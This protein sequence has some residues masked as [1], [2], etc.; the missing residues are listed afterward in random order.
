MED[1]R[2]VNQAGW[3]ERAP[4]HAASP[5]YDVERFAEDPAFLSKVVRFD[6]PLLGDVTGLRGVHL[7]CH[8]GTDTISL[9]RLGASMTGLDY[10]A[11]ALALARQL[12]ERTGDDATFVQADVYDAAS[13]LGGGRFDLVFTGI[14]ALCWLPSIRRWAEVVAALLRPGGRLFIRE[15]HPMLGTV[16]DTSD[17]K[18]MIEYP[19]F[20]RDEPMTWSQGGTYVVTDAVFTQNTS[21]EW[22]HG[23]GE[24]ITALMDAGMAITGLTEH[25]SVP[26]Q[27]LPGQMERSADG[28]WRLADRPWRIPLSYTLRAVRTG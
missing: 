10:S 15:A 22:N 6:L 24:I 5:D 7:Q 11:P 8:I 18:L 13:V 9:A 17:D 23:L 16:D 27:A 4:A 14:G 25:D 28:E 3:D 12:A 2:A 19:Y 21:H 26:W 1:Y 20:E